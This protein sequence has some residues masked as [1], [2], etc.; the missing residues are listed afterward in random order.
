MVAIEVVATFEAAL[1]CWRRP[2]V[3]VAG[4]LVARFI[5]LDVLVAGRPTR[6]ATALVPNPDD[7][8]DCSVLVTALVEAAGAWLATVEVD[9][10]GAERGG[11]VVAV[12]GATGRDVVG[13]AKRLEE[14][15][16]EVVRLLEVE[17]LSVA[18]ALLVVFV[19]L[20]GAVFAVLEAVNERVLGAEEIG[21]GL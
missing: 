9:A 12:A 5:L 17:S 19:H 14:E 10:A 8:D 7:T 20:A 4:A 18:L 2:L 6:L 21:R 1:E 15:E 11:R 3:L 13:L 16:L